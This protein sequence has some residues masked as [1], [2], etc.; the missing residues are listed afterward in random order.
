MIT[1]MEDYINLRNFSGLPPTTSQLQKVDQLN[2]QP[3]RYKFVG[4]MV[5]G[6][7]LFKNL[8]IEVGN[9]TVI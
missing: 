9:V 5:D 8:D 3:T 4:K 6:S 1:N 2:S 7:L